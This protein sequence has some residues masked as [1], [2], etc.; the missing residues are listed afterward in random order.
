[1]NMS[2]S[3]LI[4]IVS[5]MICLTGCVHGSDPASL[6]AS[7]LHAPSARLERLSTPPVITLP[8]QV[9]GLETLSLD[10]LFAHAEA[11]APA[12]LTARA[13][14]ETSRADQLEASFTFPSNPTLSLGAG[15]R[16]AN[17]STGFDYEIAL[18]QTFEVAGEQTARRRAADVHLEAAQS[19]VDEVRWLTH[20][21][22]HRLA[23]LWL[24][25]QEQR[26]RA[27]LLVDFSTTMTTI[28]QTQIDAGEV[29]PL[30]LLVV[31]ADLAKARAQ[32][33]EVSQQ[34]AVISTRLAAIIG[35]P[36][37]TLPPLSGVLPEPLEP[38]PDEELL[39]QLALY[40]PSVRQRELAVELQRA[41]LALADREGAPKPSL[42]I[43]YARESS[44]GA[45]STASSQPAHIGMLTLSVPLTLWRKNQEGRARARASLT[46][47]D[48]ERAQTMRDLESELHVAS[49]AVTSALAILDIYTSD[50]IPQ[51]HA[52]FELLQ[53]AY[54][55]GEVDIHQV[56][57]T[58]E[59]L[60]DAMTQ[61][62]QAR[63]LYVDR[64][65]TL[66]GLVGTEQWGTP[67]E[68][69][70]P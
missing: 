52:H 53:R 25:V 63:A 19:V 69:H 8:D 62:T 6:P 35:W 60:L 49:A 44:P 10:V 59:R 68:S 42:G 66:E 29:S 18:S 28:T 56:S 41:R 64:A 57:Q 17:G 39:R 47:A 40:H 23:M 51:L 58:R 34:E 5:S 48:R 1:M 7:S 43:N 14:A 26:E 31:K 37:V 12:L 4:T 2:S 22:V 27:Q 16:R 46:L 33:V 67:L 70:T 21:E 20:V 32:L 15:A 61:Y 3:L 45:S 55:L 54:E 50:I 9:A 13:R 65:A 24:A 11:H 36:D 38:L 30:D